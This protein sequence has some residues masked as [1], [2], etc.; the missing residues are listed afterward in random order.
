MVFFV[1]LLLLL[2]MTFSERIDYFNKS[3]LL[4]DVPPAFELRLAWPAE[5]DVALLLLL[6][7]LLVVTASIVLDSSRTA[8]EAPE[9]FFTGEPAAVRFD[10]DVELSLAPAAPAVDEPVPVVMR[11]ETTFALSDYVA[12]ALLD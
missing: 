3:A 4:L 5:P 1:V 10:C 12:D 11:G 7:V 2:L 9:L 6:L 8:R